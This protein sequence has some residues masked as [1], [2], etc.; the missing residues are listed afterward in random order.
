MLRRATTLGAVALLGLLVRPL[1]AA[2][3][4]RVVEPIAPLPGVTAELWAGEPLTIVA[5][6]SSSTEGAGASAPE[7]SYPARLEA[8]LRAALPGR[9]VRVVNAGK[10]GETSEDMLARLDADV[11]PHTPD[12]VIWQASGNEVL[13]GADPERFLALMREGIRR[14]RGAGAEVVLMDNQRA[15]RIE[16]RPLAAAFDAAMQA[17]AASERVP[18][19][20]RSRLMRGWAAAGMPP[21]AVLAEDQLH[22]N[23]RGYAC[24]AEALAGALLRAAGGTQL[25][26]R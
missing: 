7:A 5:L 18:L 25:A 21:P 15:P 26:E 2:E 12:L 14:V 24:L 8:A 4:P 20:A 3:C 19:F 17:L 13:R 10:S 16:A 6:G 9:P 11:L 23:D 1:A 22:H